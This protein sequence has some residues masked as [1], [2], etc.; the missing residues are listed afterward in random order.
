M[1]TADIARV[2]NLLGALAVAIEDSVQAGSRDAALVALDSHPRRSVAHLS[3]ALGRSHSATVRLVDG[4]AAAGL[5]ERRTGS[6]SRSVALVLSVAGTAA[7]R[8][9]RS[10]RADV[11]ERLVQTLDSGHVDHLEPILEQLLEATATDADSPWRTCRLCD[12]AC[13]EDGRE[14]P[15]DRAAPW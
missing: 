6:D 5:L 1:R 15:V 4:M 2:A 9:V 7:A 11:L 13:C 8:E 12:E 14:C 10:R 3:R